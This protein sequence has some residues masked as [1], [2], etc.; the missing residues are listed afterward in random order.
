M[1]T[2]N[3]WQFSS[4]KKFTLLAIATVFVS[5][6]FAF[7]GAPLARVLRNIYGRWLYWS[8]GLIS[9]GVIFLIQPTMLAYSVAA[10]WVTIGV[11]SEFEEN[12]W[13]GFG[14]GAF[15]VAL[16]SLLQII[17]P[18]YLSFREDVEK[19]TNSIGNQADL[20]LGISQETILSLLPS[21]I[22]VA[23]LLALVFALVLDKR[24]GQLAGLRFERIASQIRLLDFQ[25]PDFTIWIMLLSFLFSFLE[26]GNKLVTIIAMN[27][28]VVMMAFFF[29]QGLAVIE[30]GMLLWRLGF[31]WRLPFYLFVVGQLF[32]ILSLI[33][34]L[35]YWV[36]FRA[37]M[38]RWRFSEKNSKNGEHI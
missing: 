22:I 5:C 14:A 13:A 38:R 36:N 35:D 8:F 28:F 2:E 10:I 9:I 18:Y 26:V 24:M 29:L 15:S 31:F 7:L 3:M 23:N 12:G 37:R 30:F 1:Q 16:G 11:Y 21:G 33:G 25:L 4:I 32:F 19:M 34:V 20:G 6:F 17:T 27:T